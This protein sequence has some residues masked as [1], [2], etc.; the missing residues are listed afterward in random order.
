MQSQLLINVHFF[1]FVSRYSPAL[2]FEAAWAL[3]NVASGTSEQTNVVVECGAVPK[4]VELIKSPALNVAE[5][6]IW[7]LG[8]IAGDGP[9]ARDLVLSHGCMP[10]LVDSIKPDTTVCN[11]VLIRLLTDPINKYQS[12]VGLLT[13]RL[14]HR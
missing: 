9:A 12:A 4:L 3:T 2:Q 6:A 8:N 7:A 10:L 1:S 5:Q 14:I 13:N 11:P